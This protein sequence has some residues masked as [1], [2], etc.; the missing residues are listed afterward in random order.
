MPRHSLLSSRR[1]T[2][3]NSFGSGA[4]TLFSHRVT[5]SLHVGGSHRM[6]LAMAGV[7]HRKTSGASIIWNWLSCNLGDW[8][9]IILSA[10]Q[11]R[12]IRELIAG[13]RTEIFPQ[14]GFCGEAVLP[15]E[16]EQVQES[17]MVT[18]NRVHKG[19]TH[20]KTSQMLK[21]DQR[22]GMPP[23]RFRDRCSGIAF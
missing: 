23:F 11:P 1:M 8:M 16:N 15:W 18:K 9:T 12:I 13:E 2:K 4:C 19:L 6:N 14:R 21:Y 20:R 10:Y 22:E 3:E 5:Y 7:M 17:S